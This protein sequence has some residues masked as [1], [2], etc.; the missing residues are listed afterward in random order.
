M[1]LAYYCGVSIYMIAN[2]ATLPELMQ[3][4]Q[5]TVPEMVEEIQAR[6]ETLD[7]CRRYMFIEWLQAH[8]SR[9]KTA[10][11]VYEGLESWFESMH[12]DNRRWE[13]RLIM[14]EIDWWNNLDEQSLTKIMFADL[15]KSGEQ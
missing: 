7:P 13:Y 8:N 15:A 1:N 5:L 2:P 3:C 10:V 9:V 14:C 4:D 12:C 6:Y 11:S